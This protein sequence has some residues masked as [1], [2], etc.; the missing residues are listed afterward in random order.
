MTLAEAGG[1]VFDAA[2]KPLDFSK[3]RFLD[4]ERGII[5]TNQKL[6]P[7]VLAAVQGAIRDEQSTTKSPSPL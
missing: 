2:G 4:L 7:D 1:V 6:Q 3:G 5:A